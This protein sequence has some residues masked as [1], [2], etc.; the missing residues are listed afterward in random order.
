MCF[1]ASK[2]GVFQMKGNNWGKER[3]PK[4]SVI[5]PVYNTNAAYLK[6]AIESVLHQT[7][8]NFELLLIDNGSKPFIKE[9]I[10][11]YS[12]KRLKY[13]RLEQ[14][15]GIAVAR[16]VGI[17]QAKGEYIALLD[18][19]DVALPERFEKQVQY[20]ES[21][22][23]IGCLGTMVEIIG[24]D[25]LNAGFQ[26]VREHAEIEKFLIF[27]G[28]AFCNS[29]VMIRKS[30]LRKNHILYKPENVPAEDYGLYV[31][32][33]GKTQFAC[34]SDVLVQYRYH[35]T[36]ISHTNKQEQLEK[37]AQIQKQA[38]MKYLVDF[39]A[40]E[41]D[42]LQRFLTNQSLSAEELPRL[43]ELMN[44][45][46]DDLRAKNWS[47]D[48]IRHIFKKKAKKLYYHTRSLKG[49]WILLQKSSF[50]QFFEL[51]LYWRFLCFITRGVFK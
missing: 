10:K 46:I 20:L 30:V 15:Q 31:D 36:N 9:V 28:S 25:A 51:P 19:D 24:D 50:N 44:R 39:K 42:L 22:S 13:I 40:N 6:E 49:Q 18:S 32:L 2:R 41:I 3:M 17:E 7:Y 27:I 48:E 26:K 47:D 29:S 12:D 11:G 4:I 1:K 37:A 35:Q 38:L 14:N 21:H 43:F 16:N 23:K 34:L 33:I 8:Q 5:M 45:L